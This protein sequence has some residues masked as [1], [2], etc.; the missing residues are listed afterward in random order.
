MEDCCQNKVTFHLAAASSAA[1]DLGLSTET[2]PYLKMR[3]LTLNVVLCMTM[4]AVHDNAS[5]AGGS[6][7]VEQ[8]CR[9]R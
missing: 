4:P 7:L 9:T 8:C 6:S 1:L 2:A 5:C 3:S